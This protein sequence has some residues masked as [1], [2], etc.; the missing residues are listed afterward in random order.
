MPVPVP[1]PVELIGA[2]VGS[3]LSAVW[4]PQAI[5]RRL[6]FFVG[7]WAFAIGAGPEIAAHTHWP[8]GSFLLAFVLG[9]CSMSFFAKVLETWDRFNL[10]GLARDA[11][12]KWIGLPSKETAPAPLT[13]KE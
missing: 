1:S 8:P 11:A 13:P 2:G 12:R 3:A 4:L 9:T 6:V 7:G 5:L 10:G